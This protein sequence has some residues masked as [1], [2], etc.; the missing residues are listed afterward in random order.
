[1]EAG[2][3]REVRTMGWKDTAKAAAITASTVYGAAT[4]N[5]PST[6]Q[7]YQTTQNQQRIEVAVKQETAIGE[8]NAR[9]AGEHR[10]K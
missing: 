6:A 7:H 9:P 5:P 1:M 4:G 10:R 8:Q 2:H 3:R